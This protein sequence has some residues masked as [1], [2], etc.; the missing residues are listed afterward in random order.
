[1]DSTVSRLLICSNIRKCPHRGERN[2]ARCPHKRAHRLGF[3]C[4]MGDCEHKKVRCLPID[5]WRDKEFA[6]SILEGTHWKT[7]L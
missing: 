4:K 1:M 7:D 6:K 3:L 5:I 2:Y